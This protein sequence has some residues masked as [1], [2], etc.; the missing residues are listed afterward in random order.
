[1]KYFTI[2]VGSNL[3]VEMS[4]ENFYDLL[5]SYS[6]SYADFHQH[7]ADLVYSKSNSIV[8]DGKVFIREEE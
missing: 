5:Y 7:L 2:D 4:R 3:M 6:L 1:M 8:V